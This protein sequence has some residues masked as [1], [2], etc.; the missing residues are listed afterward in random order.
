MEQREV[1]RIVLVSS[2]TLFILLV[3]VVTLLVLFQR[4]KLKHELEKKEQEQ[5]FKQEQDKTRIEIQENALKNLAWELHDNIG[6]LLSVA[7]MQL[8]M[9]QFQMET[10]KKEKVAEISEVLKITLNEVRSLSKTLNPEVVTSIGLKSAI[11][12]EIDR[13]K[14]LQFIETVFIVNGEE[15]SI[16][17]KDE[18]IIFRII[19]EFFSN[20]IKHSKAKN[21]EVIMD[22][23]SNNELVINLKD[24]G[25]GFDSGML[26]KGSGLIN[27]TSRA[28]MINATVDIQS[29]KG[30]G[31]TLS[32]KYP[33][34]NIVLCQE[35]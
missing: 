25:R 23:T 1:L 17:A 12:T 6:Q 27:I 33:L 18:L 14:R 10:D 5:A 21:L 11:Q 26:R 30:K 31:V 16:D 19:Q 32:F 29:E 4:R 20:T 15:R 7:R 13:F 2:V 8:N 3:M 22:Y 34:N 28:K 35:K 9:L 24:D